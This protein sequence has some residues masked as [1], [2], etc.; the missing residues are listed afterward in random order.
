MY[1]NIALVCVLLVGMEL[2]GQFAYALIKGYPLYDSERRHLSQHQQLFELHP[3]LAARLRAN[4][5]VREGDKVVTATGM[6]TRWTGP[7]AENRDAIRIAVVG[8]STT[9]ATGVSDE[10]SWPARLQSTLGPGYVVTNYGMPGYSTAEAIVQL[11][12]LIPESQPDIVILYEGWNDLHNFHD[13]ELGP[14]Y[15]SHGLRQHSNLSVLRPQPTGLFDKLAEVSA[16]C[17]LARFL[18]QTARSKPAGDD[19]PPYQ[20]VSMARATPDPFVEQ[21]Y[22][23][24]L[25]TMRLLAQR[26]NAYVLFIPQVLDQSRYLGTVG[27]WWTPTIRNDAMPHLLTRMNGYVADACPPRDA[28]CGVLDAPA[29]RSWK[30]DDFIDEGHF[31]VKG[32]AAFAAVVAAQLAADDELRAVRPRSTRPGARHRTLAAVHQGHRGSEGAR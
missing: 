20:L 23:R 21:I 6:H 4:V 25:E 11:A 24:N 28:R 32:N 13:P 3:F 29:A 31:S 2:G 7:M 19:N 9:F 12:L 15:Y 5:S 18:S 17:R 1:F 16:I 22:R 8:G 30:S 26:M 10:E 14:D 27:S